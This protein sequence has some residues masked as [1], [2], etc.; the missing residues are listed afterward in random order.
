M[1]IGSYLDFYKFSFATATYASTLVCF[2]RAKLKHADSLSDRLASLTAFTS[3]GAIDTLL[4]P[5]GSVHSV[6]ESES[7]R[8]KGKS[9]IINRVFPSAL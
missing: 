7:G 5:L 4:T 1:K 6:L 3:E 2:L 8:S 9:C